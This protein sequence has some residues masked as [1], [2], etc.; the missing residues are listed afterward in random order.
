MDTPNIAPTIVFGVYKLNDPPILDLAVRQAIDVGIRLIDTAVMYQND[1]QVAKIIKGTPAKAG[2]KLRRAANVEADLARSVDLFGSQLERV[3]LHKP[4]PYSAYAV[5]EDARER[6]LVNKIGVCNYSYD[7][8]EALLADARERGAAPPDVVQNE[9]HPSLNTPV[10]E[11]CACHG[12]TFEAHSTMQAMEYIAPLAARASSQLSSAAL[13][14][15]HC[16]ARGA[17]ALCITTTKY[18][19]LQENLTAAATPHPADRLRSLLPDDALDELEA[20]PLTHPVCKYGRQTSKREAGG[21]AGGDGVPH[22]LRLAMA[23]ATLERDIATFEAGGVPSDLCLTLPKVARAHTAAMARKAEYE[24]AVSLARALFGEGHPGAGKFDGLMTKMRHR[25][26]ENHARRKRSLEGKTCKLGPKDAVQKAEELPVDIPDGESFEALLATLHEAHGPTSRLTTAGAIT[27]DGRLDLCKQV[28]R[29]RFGDLVDAIGAAAPGVVSHFLVGNN[30]IFKRLS[31]AAKNNQADD[32]VGDDAASATAA[33]AHDDGAS[34]EDEP[35][36]PRTKIVNEHLKAF[37]QLTASAQPIK[38]YYLA[39]NGITAA[40]A[41]PIANA[42]KHAKSLES[43]WL[44]MNPI[45]TGAFYFGALAAASRTLLLL[46]LFNTGLLDAGCAALADGLTSG[47]GSLQ[48]T[49]ALQHL[50]LN[51]NGLTPASLQSLAAIVAA[52]PR[53][54]SLFIGENELGDAA[55]IALLTNAPVRPAFKRL[56]IGSNGLSDAF[57]PALDAFVGRHATSMVALE[58]SSYKSTH[59][60]R[61]TPNLFGSTA[62]GQLV[63]RNLA[64]EYGLLYL[65]LDNC[66]PSRKAA[67]ALLP[68]LTATAGKRVT[69]NARQRRAADDDADAPPPVLQRILS[70]VGVDSHAA[71]AITSSAKLGTGVLAAAAAAAVLAV[72]VATKAGAAPVLRVAAAATTCAAAAHAATA[73]ATPAPPPLKLAP[74]ATYGAAG[75]R[76]IGNSVVCHSKEELNEIRHPPQLPYV[77]SIYRNKM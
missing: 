51:V 13:S 34:N 11:L 41:V 61:L 69:V 68:K 22:P 57:L 27:A 28:V 76:R 59:Y 12:I 66:L 45:S 67:A 32:N 44:K 25:V 26:A 70:D 72:V 40:S 64:S 63:L 43:L 74:L 3:L 29:P 1:E 65:G 50:Y 53:L 23:Q 33:A 73:L 46:D 4:M 38:T 75:V 30:V 39:G 20:L 42:L 31:G 17:H 62:A 9:L 6:G 2:T 18:E 8:L 21:L 14:L 71:T 55:A 58:L 36:T 15:L 56:E 37:E 35:A 48:L 10:I 5:L 7:Q 77:M 19:H 24:L 54:E 16:A 49:P 60:F 47:G 52:L